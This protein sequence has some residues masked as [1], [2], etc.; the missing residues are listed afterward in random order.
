M[1]AQL[2]RLSLL[3]VVHALVVTPDA[4]AQ[5]P[6]P[7]NIPPAVQFVSVRTKPLK[8]KPGDVVHVVAIL[9]VNQP[10]VAPDPADRFGETTALPHGMKL[11]G[12]P[13][14]ERKV[15]TENAGGELAGVMVPGEWTM[16][17]DVEVGPDAKLGD[18]ALEMQ[19]NYRPVASGS[20][21]PLEELSFRARIKTVPRSFENWN[22][23]WLVP[24]ALVALPVLL[25]VCPITGGCDC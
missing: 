9:K 12:T 6:A 5:A 18:N 13:K 8:A 20:L 15:A 19:V 17:F 14:F 3:L 24:L 21:A 16:S 4:F 23:L 11:V 22:L 25:I 7:P 2:C 1:L 10:V